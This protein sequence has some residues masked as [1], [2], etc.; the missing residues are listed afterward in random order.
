MNRI[1]SAEQSE[2]KEIISFIKEKLINLNFSEEA[3][4]TAHVVFDEFITNIILY[5]Y[6]NYKRDYSINGIS[7]E[8]PLMISFKENL[9]NVIIEIADWGKPFNPLEYDRGFEDAMGAGGF[10]IH[11]AK[12][13]AESIKYEREEG[14]NILTILINPS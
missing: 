13:L 7:Y 3:I 8:K 5:A 14:K 6:K 2:F 11:I 4:N 9:K 10:G 12:N 1:F